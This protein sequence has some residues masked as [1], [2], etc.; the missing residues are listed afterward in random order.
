M[1]DHA[2]DAVLEDVDV[3]VDQ[4]SDWAAGEFENGLHGLGF[5]QTTDYADDSTERTGSSPRRSRRT[6]RGKYI[7]I[8]SL[9]SLRASRFLHLV[10]SLTRLR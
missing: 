7:L 10:V 5:T 9:W 3:K 4:Q 2:T 6:Q 8:S 1:V